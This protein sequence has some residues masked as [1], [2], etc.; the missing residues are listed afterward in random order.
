M[1]VTE[2]RGKRAT[3]QPVTLRGYS[4]QVAEL[5]PRMRDVLL[6]AATGKPVKVTALELHVSEHTVRTIRSAACS[7]L[8]VPNV[9]A[10]VVELGRRGELPP[11]NK[12]T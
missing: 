8:G 6:S 5:T 9:V 1:H 12:V 11:T 3:Y 4:D 10:A 2:P 7:R